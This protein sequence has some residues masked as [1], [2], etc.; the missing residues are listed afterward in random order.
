MRL[1][2]QNLQFTVNS[3]VLTVV[4]FGD[5]AAHTAADWWLQWTL[6]QLL[7]SLDY[8]LIQ[9]IN[10]HMLWHGFVIVRVHFY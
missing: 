2:I 4:L 10:P 1:T 3:K 8:N 7:I 5:E 6:E 9:M